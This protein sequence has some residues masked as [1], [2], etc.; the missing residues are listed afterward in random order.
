MTEN[1]EFIDEVIYEELIKN[2]DM[3]KGNT[4]WDP[5]YLVIIDN[6]ITTDV[7]IKKKPESKKIINVSNENDTLSKLD[8]I[9]DGQK[10]KFY[11]ENLNTKL[12]YSLK[13]PYVIQFNNFLKEKKEKKEKRTENKQEITKENKQ[14][15][16]KENRED[17]TEKSQGSKQNSD[18]VQVGEIWKYKGKNGKTLRGV[19]SKKPGLDGELIND[20]TLEEL[21]QQKEGGKRKSKK[22]KKSKTRKNSRK[23]NRHRR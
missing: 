16:T 22:S 10:K 20:V 23:T 15:I 6:S 2:N 18:R 21:I 5:Y 4:E 12:K 13:N 7:Y 14:E 8:I 19:V 3:E 17:I 11:I 1:V 9:S